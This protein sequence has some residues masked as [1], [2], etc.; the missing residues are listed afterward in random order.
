MSRVAVAPHVAWV[1][2]EGVVYVAALP[3]GPPLVLEGPGAVVWHALLPGGSVDDVAE[4]VAAEVGASADAVVLDVAGF[5][6][7]LVR[8]GVATQR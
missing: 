6:D 7:D 8:A 5:L 3:D 1:E 4:R 2:D